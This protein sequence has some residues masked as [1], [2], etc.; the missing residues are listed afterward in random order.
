MPN[1]YN[2]SSFNPSEVPQ[3]TLLAALPRAEYE[4]LLPH[5]RPVSLPFGEVLYEVG[6]DIDRIYFPTAG[7]VSLVLTDADGHDVEAGIMGREG[8]SG[9]DAVLSGEPAAHRCLVQIQGSGLVIPLHA[10][11]AEIEHGGMLQTLVLR[12]TRTLLAQTAQ[13]VLCHA[14]HTVEER[15]CRWMLM[16][17]DRIGADEFDI[18]QEFIATM[19][20]A[21]RSTVTMVAGTLR[22]AGLL[23]YAYGHIRLLDRHGL[24]SAT[25]ECY[26]V[27]R[28]LFNR[29]I[30]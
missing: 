8:L 10:L 25:C 18:T 12:Y 19:L 29:L 5:L 1:S 24:E 15:M 20:G 13:G 7:L 17:A 23:D 16:V 4:R 3:S 27:I 14:G 21:R 22:S 6:D 30:D 2:S 26:G 11:R 28:D 9:L